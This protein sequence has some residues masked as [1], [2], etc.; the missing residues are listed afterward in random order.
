MSIVSEAER[1][2]NGLLR[3]VRM[4]LNNMIR[5]AVVDLVDDSKKQQQLQALVMAGEVQDEIENFEH[6]GLTTRMPKGSELV[7]LRVGGSGD[8]Q[9]AI[10]SAF[11]SARPKL[12][13]DKDVT[14]WDA[15]GNMIE[16]IRTGIVVTLDGTNTLELG[17]GA[18]K[19]VNR[20]GDSVSQNAAYDA[21][22]DLVATATSTAK[23]GGAFGTTGTGSAVVKA[24]D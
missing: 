22:F 16:L 10:A 4:R 14:L 6:Y 17:A 9:I 2:I 8:H 23:P 12:A 7:L 5:R 21:W 20:E 15:D 3:P 24:V 1:V 19:G 13:A 18:T 11:R